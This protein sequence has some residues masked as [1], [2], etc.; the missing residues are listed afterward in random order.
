MYIFKQSLTY[1]HKRIYRHIYTIHSLFRGGLAYHRNHFCPPAVNHFSWLP[2]QVH[3]AKLMQ[4]L[5]LL[6]FPC[7]YAISW[8]QLKKTISYLVSL[9]CCCF[10]CHFAVTEL[11]DL[12]STRLCIKRIHARHGDERLS[13]QISF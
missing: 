2:E 9:Y 4:W 7:N 6:R 8:M 10:T 5:P 13:T 11:Y 3:W 1:L 12:K